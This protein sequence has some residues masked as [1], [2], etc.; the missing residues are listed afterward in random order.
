MGSSKTRF[1][2]SLEVAV[3]D[4]Y[5]MHYGEHRNDKL[6][7]M[8]D[9]KLFKIAVHDYVFLHFSQE[10]RDAIKEAWSPK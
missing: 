10:D 3:D 2:D 1:V 8:L 5:Y 7:S 6:L 4:W 9:L